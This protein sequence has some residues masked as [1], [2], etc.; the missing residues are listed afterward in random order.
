MR[1]R[2]VGTRPPRNAHTWMPSPEPERSLDSE[3]C[4]LYRSL[5]CSWSS[6][7]D[8]SSGGHSGA[9]PAQ[10]LI[11]ASRI[12]KAAAA[13]AKYQ[14]GWPDPRAQRSSNSLRRVDQADSST[15]TGTRTQR[16]K[17][18]PGTVTSGPVGVGRPAGLTGPMRWSCARPT[19]RTNSSCSERAAAM[20]C[21]S[22]SAHRAWTAGRSTTRE[23]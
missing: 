11:S 14:R 16:R 22:S 12:R 7:T 1:R 13:A 20:A 15:S 23:A 10:A 8:R 9:E 21:E 3:T 18:Q 2:E 6:C 5:P 17:K 4:V 19:V